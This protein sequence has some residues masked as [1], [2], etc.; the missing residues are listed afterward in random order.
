MV[1]NTHGSK[2]PIGVNMLFV[3]SLGI[4]MYSVFLLISNYSVMPEH[5]VIHTT[6]GESDGFG[7]KYFLILTLLINLVLVAMV[8]FVARNPQYA[9]Y[10]G[11]LTKENKVRAYLY[12]RYAL[13][14]IAVIISC[15]F[16]Q[17]ITINI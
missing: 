17:A 1:G 8:Y 3:F 16:L 4:F 2:L 13:G 9:S 5:V 12:M 15:V 10:A 7:G 14:G 6:D 11:M